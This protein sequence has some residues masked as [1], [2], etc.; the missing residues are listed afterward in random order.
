MQRS[1]KHLQ[2]LG[3]IFEAYTPKSIIKYGFSYLLLLAFSFASSVLLLFSLAERLKA[4]G[5]YYTGLSSFPGICKIYLFFSLCLCIFIK[6]KQKKIS[7]LLLQITSIPILWL[8]YY[9]SDTLDFF[10]FLGVALSLFITL[11]N[12]LSHLDLMAKFREYWRIL[13]IM[14]LVLLALFVLGQKNSQKKYWFDEYAVV[15]SIASGSKWWLSKHSLGEFSHLHEKFA[16]G[17]KLHPVPYIKPDTIWQATADVGYLETRPP[18]SDSLYTFFSRAFGLHL[19]ILRVLPQ[20][21]SVFTLVLLYFLLIREAKL[22]LAL[23]ASL[24]LIFSPSALQFHGIDVRSY[25]FS[26]FYALLLISAFHI[27]LKSADIRWQRLWV[28]SSIFLVW[29]HYFG[30]FLIG[31][32]GLYCLFFWRT[33]PCRKQ[34]LLGHIVIFISS[35]LLLPIALRQK[36]IARDL[37]EKALGPYSYI[38]PESLFDYVY[39]FFPLSRS[40]IALSYVY[41]AFIVFLALFWVLWRMLKGL[42]KK[43]S[44]LSS[45]PHSSLD[46]SFSNNQKE[47]RDPLLFYILACVFHLFLYFFYMPCVGSY[48][49]LGHSLLESYLPCDIMHVNQKTIILYGIEIPVDNIALPYILFFLLTLIILFSVYYSPY[50]GSKIKN[51]SSIIVNEAPVLSS[52]IILFSAL[53][54][55]LVINIF[56]VRIYNNRNTIFLFGPC[57][58]LLFLSPRNLL[59][60]FRA[61]LKTSIP[62]IPWKKS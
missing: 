41:C 46:T 17:K 24:V 4:D 2:A 8:L 36:W 9:L 5:L 61:C 51:N 34:I 32:M 43:D 12:F 25:I 33:M 60:N 54:M 11:L 42:R 49:V 38:S 15:T 18:L 45:G 39:Y 53:L 26:L 50:L 47:L 19:A 58:L 13:I 52:F 10:A 30:F 20:I 48:I 3:F 27:F 57:L 16:K 59:S 21:I 7:F 56:G 31:A 29:N 22:S 37:L 6:I 62:S 1:V 35:Y 55:Y 40:S 44:A 14:G 23:L 28:L